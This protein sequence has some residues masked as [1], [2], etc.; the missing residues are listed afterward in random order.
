MHGNL[1]PRLFSIVVLAAAPAAVPGSDWPLFRGENRDGVSAD[2]GIPTTWSAD[3]NVKW[4]AP[5]PRPGNSSPIV[6]NGR[7]F[8][9]CA[10]DPRGVGRSLYCFN[11]AD[12]RR[13]WSKTVTF[14][15]AEPSHAT[16]PYCATSPAADG[17]RVVVW[18]GS[19]GVHCYDFEGAEL[20]SRNLGAFRQIWG[21][22]AS[23]VF[24]G[25]AVVLNCGPGAR[26]F[27][28]ALDKTTGKT[29]WQT[30]EPGGADDKS[31]ETHNWVGSWATPVPAV[32]G[33]VP[34]IL[35]AQ[36]HHVNSY[37]PATGRILWTCGGTGD[38]AYA[39]PLLGDG[40]CVALAG[41]GGAAIGFKTTGALSGDIT[42]ANRL[43]R[44]AEKNPQRIGSGILT[45]GRLFMANE[46]GVITCT[47]AETGKEL[48][49][50][51]IA[52]EH[53][54]GSLIRVGDK[55]Y[56][57]SQRGETY[58]FAA[59]PSGYH[60]LALND[61]GEATNSTPAPS[62]RDLFIRTAG[63]LWCISEK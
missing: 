40:V 20:W 53:F 61:L 8:S 45:G 56:A 7:V 4:K 47:D 29:L 2:A 22:A 21:H 46:P 3:K 34:Q 39:D 1:W 35:V 52:N 16:N 19:A 28:I 51:R 62:G 25:D 36:P 48:W 42:E 17:Q 13:L 33:G 14:E 10:E 18:H 50:Q 6:S 11:R 24:V 27:V 43:W 30:D 9:T 26:S 37:D 60:P 54:W 57:T 41:Y 49:R 59:D 31:A 23:P 32:L 15:Q 63:H 44:V 58:V 5:L 38:L 12:G 55:L